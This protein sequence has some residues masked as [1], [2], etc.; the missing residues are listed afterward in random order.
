MGDVLN[1]SGVVTK[2][3]AMQSKLLKPEQ[4]EEIA[5]LHSVPEVVSYLKE[6]TS[7]TGILETLDEDHLH[8]GD[9]E[10]IMV[11]TLYDDFSKIYSFCGLEQRKFLK[12]YLRHYEVDLINYCLRI[13]INHYQE[14]FD[15]N[16]KKAFFDKYSKISIEKLITSR[17]TDQLIENL[18]GTEYY[19]P[20]KSL[21]DSRSVTLFDYDLTLN[22]YCYMVAWKTRAK[23]KNKK[24]RDLFVNE[25]GTMIDLLNLEWIYRAKKYYNMKAID[26]FAIIIPNH[27]RIPTD[28][29]KEIVEAPTVDDCIKAIGKSFYAN[30]FDPGKNKAF[31]QMYN[32]ILYHMYASNRRKDPYSIAT[33]NAYLFFKEEE[34]KKLTTA[35]EC[36][37]YS[38]SPSETLAYVGGNVND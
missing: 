38:L 27:Y 26:I 3:R 10:K 8:R 35:M 30:R 37:R 18:K 11:Q 23:I 17:T 4:F 33:V 36:I 28:M 14:P 25:W 19:T 34:L 13:V 9:I 7:Y 5:N 1:Y 29:I 32:E 20:L 22:L 21:Q 2:I 16:Y 6:K 31:E 12:L 15:I 24:E